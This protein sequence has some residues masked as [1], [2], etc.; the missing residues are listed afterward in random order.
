MLYHESHV[1]PGTTRGRAAGARHRTQRSQPEPS[2][3]YSLFGIFQ[4]SSVS[5]A[6][7][8]WSAGSSWQ[9]GQGKG[10]PHARCVSGSPEQHFGCWSSCRAWPQAGSDE[11]LPKAERICSDGTRGCWI[12]LLAGLCFVHPSV[13]RGLRPQSPWSPRCKS[14]VAGHDL[15]YDAKRKHGDGCSHCQPAPDD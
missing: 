10:Y 12:L 6:V 8:L 15:Y 1:G 5:R 11:M 3:V 14:V 7:Q 2:W 9:R 13:R 4:S